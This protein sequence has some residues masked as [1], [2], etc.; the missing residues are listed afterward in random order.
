MDWA[1]AGSPNSAANAEATEMKAATLAAMK[2]FEDAVE[3]YDRALQFN[4]TF[5]QARDNRLNALFE[6]KQGK[7]CPPAYMRGLFDDFSSHYDE[8]MLEK[9]QYRAHLHLRE[10]ADRVLPRVTPPWRILALG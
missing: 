1:L 8:T 5:E 3:S 10:L 6:L 7:R 4:P 9:L 2:R